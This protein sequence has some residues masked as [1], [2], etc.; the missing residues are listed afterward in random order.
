M[1]IVT[2]DGNN[3]ETPEHRKNRT[4]RG[5][6]LL[7]TSTSM[8]WYANEKERGGRDGILYVQA[9]AIRLWG[10]SRSIS[11]DRWNDDLTHIKGGPTG[12]DDPRMNVRPH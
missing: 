11:P 7:Y 12:R 3:R 9:P 2:T 6:N 8:V 4:E 5:S 1:L 10:P